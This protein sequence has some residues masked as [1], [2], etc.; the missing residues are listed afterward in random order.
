MKYEQPVCLIY[1]CISF[2]FFF[3]VN[4][5]RHWALTCFF[6]IVFIF[7]LYDIKYTSAC[8]LVHFN[9]ILNTSIFKSWTAME[10]CVYVH[11]YVYV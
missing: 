7:I 6:F 4:I 9:Y 11:A 8:T 10:G 5:Q 3:S 2:F 1:V